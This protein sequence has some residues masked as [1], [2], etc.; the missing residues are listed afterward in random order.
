[1][2]E[3]AQTTRLLHW[4]ARMRAGDLAA[5][6]ELIRGFQVRLELLARKMV[7]RD[8]RIGRWVDTEDVLHVGY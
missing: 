4:V 3:P 2:S 6:D 1:M 8:P 7:G 5:H